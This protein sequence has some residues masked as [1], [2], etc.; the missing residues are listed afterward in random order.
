MR[1]GLGLGLGLGVAQTGHI[2]SLPSL[3]LSFFLSLCFPP[4]TLTLSLTNTLTNVHIRMALRY[5]QG[6]YSGHVWLLEGDGWSGSA[7]APDAAHGLLAVNDEF[8]AKQTNE[9]V[10]GFVEGS[11]GGSVES[12]ARNVPLRLRA[13]VSAT[14]PSMMEVEVEEEEVVM[15]TKDAKAGVGDGQQ[16]IIF[17]LDHAV[18]IKALPGVRKVLLGPL[19]KGEHVVQASRDGDATPTWSNQVVLSVG[20]RDDHD[21][22]FG[23]S[24]DSPGAGAGA[25]ADAGVDA[26][27][28]AD[29]DA[30][31]DATVAN[32]TSAG[33]LSDGAGTDAG[34]G[35]LSARTY[36]GWGSR[37]CNNTYAEL[38]LSTTEEHDLS[39]TGL[40]VW[41]RDNCVD[42]VSLA[43]EKVSFGH[44]NLWFNYVYLPLLP[45]T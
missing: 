4:H 33:A 36:S 19:G 14:D 13:S 45:P 10:E 15:V 29:T 35:A 24:A 3:F 37:R 11:V 12:A 21:D 41:R 2:A 38:S 44:P 42:V 30:S 18:Q 20:P 6:T 22:C 26:G 7:E 32:T 17:R 28:D 8:I 9:S 43:V 5:Q 16:R 23:G 1:L 40:V 27:A 39:Y 25:G 31:A 34:G